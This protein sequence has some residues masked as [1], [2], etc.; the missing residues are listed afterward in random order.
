VRILGISGSLRAGSYNSAL[1]RA[2]VGLAPDGMAVEVYGRLREVPP[3]DADL[4]VD[5]LPEPAADLRARI[6]AADGLLIATPEYNY[7]V[8]GV[9]KNAVDWASR[10]AGRSSLTRKPVAIMGAAPGAFGTVRAQLAL[11]QSF[12][13]TDSGVVTKPEV[14]VFQAAGRFDAAGNLVDEGARDLVAKL[15]AGLAAKIREPA[16]VGRPRSDGRGLTAEV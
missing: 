2:A 16:E 4:D 12:L 14:H 3:Y 9:L 11:R 6:A 5:P 10:P 13:R 8:P 15:L 7:G 1:L